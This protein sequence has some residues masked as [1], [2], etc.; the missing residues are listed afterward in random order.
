MMQPAPQPGD[1]EIHILVAS[2]NPDYEQITQAIDPIAHEFTAF[3]W[4]FVRAT[5]SEQHTYTVLD[6]PANRQHIT[7]MML[8]F[9]GIDLAYEIC[10]RDPDQLR[11]HLEREA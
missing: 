7:A 3:F 5:G 10:D 1:R 11:E 2:N 8:Q 9:T 6:T 4:P